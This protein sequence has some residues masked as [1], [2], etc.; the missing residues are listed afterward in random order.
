MKKKED[1]IYRII[2]LCEDNNIDYDIDELE[3]Y[4]YE[5]LKIIEQCISHGFD[6][7]NPRKKHINEIIHYIGLC[8]LEDD[9]YGED[10]DSLF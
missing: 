7:D 10:I 8:F 9:L 1:M 2:C 4:C 6:F 3:E 5:E